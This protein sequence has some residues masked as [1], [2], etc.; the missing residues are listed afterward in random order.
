MKVPD[1]ERVYVWLAGEA[2]QLKP[3]RRWV[4]DELGLDKGDY[5]VTGYWKRGV[6]D[7]DDDDQ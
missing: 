7:Y 4:R 1:G 3:L 6:A 2:G 5:S